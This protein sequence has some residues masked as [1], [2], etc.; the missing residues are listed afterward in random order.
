MWEKAFD[1]IQH[2]FMIKT[3]TKVG[4]IKAIYNK[5]SNMHLNGEKLKAFL[6]NSG[7]GQGC[8]LSPLLSIMVMEVLDTPIR[9][10]KEIKS[11]QIG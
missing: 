7:T 5:T 8:Y 10:E 3:I 9:E 11:R 4:I 2:L 1:K 6:L